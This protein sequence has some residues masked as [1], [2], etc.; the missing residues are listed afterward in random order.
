MP[1]C[2]RT[3]ASPDETQ[4][5]AAQI[6]RQAQSGDIYALYGNLAS[7]KTT[8]VQGF[9]RA[10]HVNEKVTSPTFTLINEYTGDLPLYHFDCYRLDSADEL[11]SLGY[12]E[13]FY[14][15]GVVLIEW[16]DRIETLLPDTVTR[17]YFKHVYSNAT[18]RSIE[19][20][21]SE[22]REDLCDSLP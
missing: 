11:F 9:C 15:D 20:H 3:T 6:A 14:G 7:G 16:A 2:S 10:L 12:E 8:F 4:T 17:I 5:L 22:A 19:L 18:T 13:Y 1:L 21:A